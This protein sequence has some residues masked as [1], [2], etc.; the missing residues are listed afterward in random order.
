MRGA[1]LA[2]LRQKTSRAAD[3]LIEQAVVAGHQSSLFRIA[4]PRLPD[5][6]HSGNSV[7]VWKIPSEIRRSKLNKNTG[8]GL[9][10]V[11]ASPDAFPVLAIRVGDAAVALVELVGELEHGEHQPALR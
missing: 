4:G 1:R 9:F 3:A 8:A 5:F 7:G 6:R 11:E 10:L 2:P